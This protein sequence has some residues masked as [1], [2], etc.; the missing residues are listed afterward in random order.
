[1]KKTLAIILTAVMVLS[2]VI[3]AIP[4][5]ASAEDAVVLDPK[6]SEG[7]SIGSVAEGYTTDLTD[8]T[9]IGTAEE[10]I[11]AFSEGEFDSVITKNYYLTAD[12]VLPDDYW[13]AGRNYVGMF[14][15][16]GY[17]VTTNEAPLFWWFWNGAGDAAATAVIKNLKIH[18]KSVISAWSD[19]WDSEK[20]DGQ[21]FVGALA[22]G[23]D[24]RSGTLTID[25]VLVTGKGLTNERNTGS[26][27]GGLLGELKR[28]LAASDIYVNVEKIEGINNTAGVVG[29]TYDNDHQGFTFDNVHVNTVVDASGAT[30]NDG[31]GNGGF[32]GRLRSLNTTIE[33]CSVNGTL[34]GDL[35]IA[36]GGF[37]GTIESGDREATITIKN[38]VNNATIENWKGSAADG[39]QYYGA[40]GF[41]GQIENTK[42]TIVI[43][44]CVNNGDVNANVNAAGF[45]GNI[46]RV[47]GV[48]IEGC[49]NNGDITSEVHAAGFIA[50]HGSDKNKATD[51]APVSFIDCENNGTI[52]GNRIGGIA[53][54]IRR[55][56]A[57]ED[58]TNNGDI[59]NTT[60]SDKGVGGIIGYLAAALP[61]T[62][63]N[64]KNTGNVTGGKH[65]AGIIAKCE[66]DDNTDGVTFENCVN[67]GDVTTTVA[68]GWVGGILGFS[69]NKVTLKNCVVSGAVTAEDAA[70]VAAII[71]CVKNADCVLSGNNVSGTITGKNSAALFITE[72]GVA[73]NDA[74]VSE[75][76]IYNTCNATAY[77]NGST[78]MLTAQYPFVI[79]N[80]DTGDNF[81][82]GIVLSI[83]AITA[84]GITAV[85]VLK[86]RV[87][88]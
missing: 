72:E 60:G 48:T 31:K 5:S 65:V 3:T 70:C 45:V 85:V 46:R 77:V 88:N 47:K 1:M 38:C 15:G 74:N 13:P 76:V 37:I 11:A 27:V 75:N 36:A 14:D 49:V 26:A 16:C 18:S 2:M 56:A 58:C 6:N 9:P 30:A 20:C 82:M 44:D 24:V 78:T 67:E 7:L 4:F 53:A 51:C 23:A 25:N 10:W 12:I 81:V 29:S 32:I 87:R 86:K 62:V 43:K 83:L 8:A 66:A 17:T 68:D 50:S 79:T 21:Q 34:Y 54:R 41:V 84:M 39:E 69:T 71:G 73:L 55:I 63:S 35:G 61:A 33:N 57:L 52:T 80:P 28:T 59:I 22:M 64:V 19:S 42:T 40:G